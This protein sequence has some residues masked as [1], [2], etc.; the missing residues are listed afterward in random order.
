[1]HHIDCPPPRRVL[2]IEEFRT[3]CNDFCY[4]DLD[5]AAIKVGF[6]YT[7]SLKTQSNP[8]VLGA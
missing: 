7:F 8:F 5:E 3:S 4:L 2:G 6:H 1:M